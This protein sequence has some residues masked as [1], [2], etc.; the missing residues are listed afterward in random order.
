MTKSKTTGTITFALCGK[1]GVGKTTIS[2][3]LVR[4]LS[5]DTS[6][7]VLAIDADPAV[8]LSTA[9]GFEPRR[10]VD[11]IRS[12][13][14]D[15]AGRG[16]GADKETLLQQIDY[17][18][19][20]ALDEKENIAFL[21][22]GRPEKAGCYC[23]VNSFLRD[24]ISTLAEGFDYVVI[25]GEAGIEQVNRRVMETVDFLLVVSDFSKKGLDVAATIER[26][27]REAVP[28]SRQGLVINR[29]REDTLPEGIKLPPAP[30]LICILPESDAV[31]SMDIKGESIFSLQKKELMDRLGSAVKG[32]LTEESNTN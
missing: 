4:I 25:D 29:S 11:E 30:E 7:K 22:I 3:A 6:K 28:T 15:R 14:I 8:G 5:E 26:V 12:D 13:L 20:E 9:L 23:S 21:A 17:E 31:R 24:I 16:E 27:A 19:F 18:I 10:T 1:G 32:L 2:A